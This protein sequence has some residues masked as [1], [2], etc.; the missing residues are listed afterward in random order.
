MF[1]EFFG[2]V[3]AI[4]GDDEGVDA[5]E[6]GIAAGIGVGGVY[7][8]GFLER[9]G[10]KLGGF[11]AVAFGDVGGF[12]RIGIDFG[13][14]E[15]AALGAEASAIGGIGDMPFDAVG[16]VESNAE[17]ILAGWFDEK[18]IAIAPSGF[19]EGAV[20][21]GGER[22]LREGGDDGEGEEE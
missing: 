10:D 13:D 19:L 8:E 1:Y 11:F 9:G 18:A 4:G 5:G 14:T 6:V 2:E 15:V 21:I 17:G 20:G 3:F 22:L 7:G 16:A 12:L